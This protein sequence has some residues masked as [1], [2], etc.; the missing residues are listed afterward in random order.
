MI[1]LHCV[2]L[3][4]TQT[5]REYE[6][7]AFTAKT[8]KFADMMTSLGH[9]V[10]LY[11]GEDNEAACTEFVT[12]ITRKQLGALADVYGP[13]DMLKASFDPSSPHWLLFNARVIENIR[14]RIAPRDFIA[15]IGGSSQRSV[16][17][18]FGAHMAVEF[19]IGYWGSFA[20]YRVFESYA[21]MHSTYAAQQGVDAADGRFYDRVIP[22]YFE[23]DALPEG[24]GGDYLAFLGRNT[25]RKGLHVAEQVA[26]ATGLPLRSAGI[27]TERGLIGPAERADLIGGARALLVPT[28][29]I[30]PFG[31]VAA[32]ALICG[33]P[34]IT[35][36]WGAF[37]EYVRQGIDGYRCHT[38]QDFVDAVHAVGDVD[39]TTIREHAIARFS[40]E[41]V[42]HEYDSYFTALLG[43][44]DDGWGALGVSHAETGTL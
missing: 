14:A 39:R 25:P 2:S 31:S 36:D 20:D 24:T 17:E 33:T 12:C 41:F 7:C 35:T 15:L 29:Y 40:T 23:V 38:L 21:V 1:R 28:L 16:A 9:E 43:L 42:R 13:E 32:E 44:W 37:P 3:P 22:N 30:E 26:A 11:A 34:V 4:H 5:T 19:G 8:R 6:G 10:V 27:G 18:A